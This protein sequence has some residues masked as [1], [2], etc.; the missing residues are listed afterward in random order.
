MNHL[1]GGEV[2]HLEGLILAPADCPRTVDKDGATPDDAGV[3]LEGMNHLA[4][5]EVPHL[6]G[7]IAARA[8]CPRTV[9]KDGKAPDPAGVPFE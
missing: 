7:F 3:P 1:A 8:D 6:E 4:G 5:G 9:G 2:P